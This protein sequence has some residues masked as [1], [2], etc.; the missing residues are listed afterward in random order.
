MLVLIL[1]TALD[2][3][4]TAALPTEVNPADVLLLEYVQ[5]PVEFPFVDE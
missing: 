4:F 2:V 5:I 3:E 1:S